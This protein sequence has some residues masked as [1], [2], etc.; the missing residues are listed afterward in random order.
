[1]RGELDMVMYQ[2]FYREHLIGVLEVNPETNKHKFTTNE[3]GVK[4]AK[5][6][7][8]LIPEMEKGTDGFVD[9]IPFFENRI[10]NM[11]RSGL[12]EINYQTDW[13]LLKKI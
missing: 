11:D 9:P 5:E 12:T 13:F 1:M 7:T 6:K 10:M 2:L 3:E 4:V 8:S